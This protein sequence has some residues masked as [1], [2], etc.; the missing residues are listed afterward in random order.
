MPSKVQIR[1]GPLPGPGNTTGLK[2]L[3]IIALIAAFALGAYDGGAGL[4]QKHLLRKRYWTTQLGPLQD[5][6]QRYNKLAAENAELLGEANMKAKSAV[7]QVLQK[8]AYS[9]EVIAANRDEI[10]KTEREIEEMCLKDAKDIAGPLEKLIGYT[11]GQLAEAESEL[12]KRHEKQ[13]IVRAGEL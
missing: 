5:E 10:E 3:P 11:Q 8:G 12:G 1:R 7:T 9:Q 2:V 4:I 13:R 6:L